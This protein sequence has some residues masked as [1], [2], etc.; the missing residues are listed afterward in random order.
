[1]KLLKLS[2]LKYIAYTLISVAL[3]ILGIVSCKFF[4]APF[5][6]AVLIS[7]ALCP[8]LKRLKRI[9]PYHFIA[10]L[11]VVLLFFTSIGVVFYMIGVQVI[12]FYDKYP[13]LDEKLNILLSKFETFMEHSLGIK[14]IN[15]T[16]TTQE[17]KEHLISSASSYVISLFGSVGVFIANITLIPL[18][19][20]LLLL[21]KNFIKCQLKKI[22]KPLKIKEQSLFKET[23]LL[24]QNYLKGLF[25]VI[26]IL[27]VCYSIG[28]F[29]IGV[30]YALSL[31]VLIALMAIVPYIGVLFGSLLVLFVSFVTQESVPQLITVSVFMGFVQFIEGNFLTPKVIGDKINLNPIFAILFLIIGEQ[32]WGITGMIVV[33]PIVAI[34]QIGVK[35]LK[36]ENFLH[37]EKQA[38]NVKNS[39]Q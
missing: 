12:D 30:P 36:K 24:I 9:I 11:I 15:L 8:L 33:L 21:Y 19:I 17:N 10:V 4:L 7:L 14:E 13:N 27:A 20:F 23:T 38:Q 18:Y 26:F 28:L 39:I 2:Y 16:K 32:I 34:A 1:M 35:N 31:G 22:V 3:V 29:V 5:T 37:P 25:L 6:V